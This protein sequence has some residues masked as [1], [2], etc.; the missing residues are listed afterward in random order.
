MFTYSFLLIV[1]LLKSS[2]QYST[3]NR[4]ANQNA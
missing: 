3:N 4:T 1:Y 2:D